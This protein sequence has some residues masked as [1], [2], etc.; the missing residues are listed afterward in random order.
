MAN[1]GG[2]SPKELRLLIREQKITTETS[3]MSSGFVQ[4]NLVI[5]PKKHADNFKKFTE[6]NPK[7]CPVLEVTE[8]GDP[9]IKRIADRADIRTDVPRYRVF[10]NG[11]LIGEPFE[12]TR[13]WQDDFICFLIGCS[14]SFENALVKSGIEVRNITDGHVV[15]VYKTGI[16]CAPAGP[17]TGPVVATMRPIHKDQVDLA[18]EITGKFPHV[19][20][21]PIYHGDPGNLGVDLEKPDWGAIT[22]F[23]EGEVPVFWACGVTPQ[24]AIENAKLDLVI[25]HSPAC[26]FVSDIMDDELESK[27]FGYK[28]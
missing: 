11:S 1:F 19:H 25:T 18:Y 9:F 10:K 22:R 24:A 7:P 12:I 20:G 26:M 3:G 23:K 16:P 6:R 2:T 14:F 8:P 5:L 4:A 21:M 13:Y 17:F 15:S 28:G 27:L